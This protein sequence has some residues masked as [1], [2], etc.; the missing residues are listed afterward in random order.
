VPSVIKDKI[1]KADPERYQFMSAKESKNLAELM[2]DPVI[3]N[4]ALVASESMNNKWGAALFLFHTLGC[5]PEEQRKKSKAVLVNI[6]IQLANQISCKG[7][8]STERIRTNYRPGLDDIDVEET[9]ENCTTYKNLSYHDLVMIDRR[10]KKR[11]VTLILDISN[12][13]QMYKILIAVLAVGVLALRL[14]DEYYSVIAFNK[15]VKTIKDMEEG[16]SIDVLLDR[17]LDLKPEGATDIKLGLDK[18]LEQLMKN[19]A[20]EK[21]AI[22]ATDGWVTVGG[23]PTMTASKMEKLHVIQVPIGRGGGDD[24]TCIKMAEAG[25]GRRIYVE[26]FNELPKAIM[27][28]LG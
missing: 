2:Q 14:R 4:G 22:I 8:R 27:E 28:I 24:R 11:A 5:V 10:K 15:D 1:E 3:F 9:L 26:D 17:M 18:G 6:V 19:I 23:D 21:V 25:R 16:L 13:M 20:H 12:S 7:F